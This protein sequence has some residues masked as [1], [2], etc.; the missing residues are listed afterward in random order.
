ML[1]TFITQKVL[2][3]IALML[4]MGFAAPPTPAAQDAAAIKK[5]EEVYAAQKCSICHAIAGKGNKQNPLDGVG[6]KLTADEIRQWITNP[7]EMTAKTKSTKKPPMPN[8][9]SKLSAADL[10]ALV[11]Y[12]QSLK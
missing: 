9:Y 6:T 1:M 11:A 12:M 2:P 8:K 5:G 7:T 10:D 4:A 3:V